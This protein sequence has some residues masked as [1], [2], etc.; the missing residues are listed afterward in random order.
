MPP[1]PLPDP[2]PPV[3]LAAEA[4]D[5][6]AGPAGPAAQPPP[7]ESGVDGAPPA[8]PTADA[9]RPPG[10]AAVRRPP[11]P[12]APPSASAA[13][14]KS[15]LP[16]ARE[17]RRDPVEAPLI[18]PP[19]G[20]AWRELLVS[21]NLNGRAVSQGTLFAERQG[22]GGTLA[23]QLAALE[24]WRVGT[25]ASR[26]ITFQGE[27]YYPLAAIEGA[28]WVLDREG[29]ALKLD[30]PAA[31]FAATRLADEREAVPPPAAGT[32]GFLDYDL[33]LTAGDDLD[34][35]L[36]GLGR[37][38][39]VLRPRHAHL[40]PPPGRPRPR[41]RG[42]PARHDAHP[43]PAGPAR[44]PAVGDSVAAGGAFAAPVR[45]GG[46]QYATNFGTDPGFVTFPLPAIGGLAEQDAVVDVLIDNLARVSGEV[47]PARS[48]STTCPWSPGRARSSSASPTCSAASAS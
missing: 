3:A 10:R 8:A 37:G 39:R 32:G 24:L 33:L 2:P 34:R 42:H 22:D 46:L 48:R 36:D 45:F 29:L 40:E 41:A 1:L 15:A 31:R 30:I 19:P 44:Q 12:P 26:V 43:R 21:V 28:K 14:A 7:A 35:R 9:G 20:G 25:D 16:T 18:D 5:P 47:P 4:A 23:I 17:L 11:P 27:P 38:R 13:P 6:A